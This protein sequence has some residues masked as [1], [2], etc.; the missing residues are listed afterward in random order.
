M[1]N[2]SLID[3]FYGRLTKR[4]HTGVGLVAIQFPY[5]HAPLL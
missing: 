5:G 1:V 3:L 4:V 2:P